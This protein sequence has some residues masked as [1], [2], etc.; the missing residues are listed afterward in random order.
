MTKGKNPPISSALRRQ[1]SGINVFDAKYRGWTPPDLVIPSGLTKAQIDKA[2]DLVFAWRA[3]AD[4]YGTPLV[5]EI[6]AALTNCSSR[7]RSK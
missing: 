1:E 2:T 5:L 7:S 4:P 6:Y 3:S